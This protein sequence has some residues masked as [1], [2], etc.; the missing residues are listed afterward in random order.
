MLKLVLVLCPG[1]WLLDWFPVLN[2]TGNNLNCLN[3]LFEHCC[4]PTYFLL[5]IVLSLFYS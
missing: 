2:T 5:I 1:I 3:D 4:N